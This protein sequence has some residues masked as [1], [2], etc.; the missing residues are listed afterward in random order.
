MYLGRMWNLGIRVLEI[1]VVHKNRR[2]PVT[3]IFIQV[4]NVPLLSSMVHISGLKVPKPDIFDR[5][6]FPNFYTIKSL[7]R[8]ADFGVKIKKKL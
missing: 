1:C 3:E 4:S 8:V 6:D 2:F 7:R 5:S